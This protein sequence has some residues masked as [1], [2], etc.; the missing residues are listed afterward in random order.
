MK[1]YEIL[2]VNQTLSKL[3]NEPLKGSF[4]FRLFRLKAELEDLVKPIAD[5]LKGVDDLE[6]QEEI[7]NVEQSVDLVQLTEGELEPLPLSIQDI[8]MLQ[9]IIQK[10]GDEA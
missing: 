1:N 8:A 3:V 7:L 5:S 4:K 2:N 9:P 10:Q 6:E